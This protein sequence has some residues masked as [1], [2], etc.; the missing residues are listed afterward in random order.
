MHEALTTAAYI[1][2][3]FRIALS[4]T[5]R[6]LLDFGR[7]APGDRVVNYCAGS[8]EL[9]L[10]IADRI[11]GDG[12]LYA[13][14]TDI[15]ALR[16]LSDLASE[17]HLSDTVRPWQ[18]NAMTAADINHVPTHVTCIFGLHELPDPVAATH[19]WALASSPATKLLT[20]DWAAV[21]DP[22]VRRRPAEKL[23]QVSNTWQLVRATTLE[24]ALPAWEPAAR[25]ILSNPNTTDRS[26]MASVVIRE[27]TQKA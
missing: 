13:V 3:T 7:C 15:E 18:H 9:N 19:R 16:H 26:V 24:F 25:R 27:W 10:A 8:A 22:T 4:G 5:V 6:T 2:A 21:W 1:D 11:A 12:V 17:Q 20:A 23:P 14:D